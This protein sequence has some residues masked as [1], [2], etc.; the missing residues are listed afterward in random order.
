VG[1]AIP[2][3][4]IV[5]LLK[6]AGFEQPEF[7]GKTGITTSKFTEGALFRARKPI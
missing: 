5:S 3:R 1:G 7:G 6:K 2:V 4:D